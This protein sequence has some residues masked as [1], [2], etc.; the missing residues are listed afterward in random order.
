VLQQCVAVCCSAHELAPPFPVPWHLLVERDVYLAECHVT[1]RFLRDLQCVAVCCIVLQYVAASTFSALSSLLYISQNVT[2]HSAS[3]TNCR[4]SQSVAGC[5]RA[6]QCVAACTFSALSNLSCILQSVTSHSAS[7]ANCSVLQRS[8]GCCR[9]LQCVAV[10]W[11]VH[12]F[13]L[14]E[15][16]VYV[17]ECHVTQGFLR[18]LRRS[19]CHMLCLVGIHQRLFARAH[20]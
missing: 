14:V 8:A 1:Q 19:H 4:V 2:S 18:E 17:A 15:L 12:L 3:C 16:V 11:R 9:A 7:C 6:L 13:G 20:S 10:C 5:C